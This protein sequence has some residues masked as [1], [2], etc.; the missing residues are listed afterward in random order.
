[1][2]KRL[3]LSGIRKDMDETNMDFL[4][5]LLPW[6]KKLPAECHKKA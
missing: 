2:V 3:P 6:S 4:E 1:M 5:E